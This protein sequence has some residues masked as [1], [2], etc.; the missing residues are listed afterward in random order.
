M[1]LLDQEL[2]NQSGEANVTRSLLALNVAQ[3]YFESLAAQ[4]GKLFGGQTGTIQMIG[5]EETTLFPPT[6]LRLDRLQLLDEST[7]RPQYDII[8]DKRAGGHIGTPIWWDQATTGTATPRSYWSDG[9]CIYW[10][11]VP[12]ESR[13]V[14]YYGFV[15]AS[16]IT[17]SRTFAYKDVVALPIASFAVRLIR[18]GID[19][20]GSDMSSLATECFGQTLDAMGNFR[21]DG[22]AG[23]EYERIHTT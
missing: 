19:D 23:F 17:A 22:A 2:Q 12:L 9:T 7:L 4:R 10:A 13:T 5:G 20:S 16:D 14:R 6:L 1:E 8:S 15:S 18:S 3:D 11:P 21:R